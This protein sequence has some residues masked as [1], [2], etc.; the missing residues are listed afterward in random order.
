[1]NISRRHFLSVLTLLVLFF[2]GTVAS[3]DDAKIMKVGIIGLD[4][5]HAIA[6][7][8]TLNKPK[9]KGDA[10][11]EG[12]RV[13]HAYPK[14]SRDIES[15]TKRVP[16]YIEKVKAMDVVIVDSIPALLEQV[17]AILLETN[18]GRPHLE[19]LV[20]CLKA[21]KPVFI[22]K[23]V[24]ASLSDAI[25]IYELADKYNVPIFSSSSLRF[26][27]ETQAISKGKL[28]E[29]LGCDTFSPCSLEKTHIDLAWYGIHGVESLFTIMGTGCKSVT[30]TS[31]KDFDKATGLWGD[32]RI[33]TFRGTRKGRH[34]YGGTAFCQKGVSN[35]VGK[36]DGYDVLLVEIVKFFKTKKVPVTKA[37]TIEIFAFMEA[38]DES[39][40]QNGAPVTIESVMKKARVE[41]DKKIKKY[42]P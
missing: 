22:D 5:S 33:G 17:D 39:K 15:S 37:E 40:R 27:K 21:G 14:G 9:G 26:A 13:T 16:D 34:G 2:G 6:F 36:Y 4:T 38:A 11:F 28:G 7:T 32:N 41:A 23:P 19:Q 1:M 10:I 31:T 24:A 18:D 8:K 3:A 20:P 42:S 29:V 25:A 35:K 12:F 30:R